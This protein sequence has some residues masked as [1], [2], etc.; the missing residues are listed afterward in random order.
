MSAVQIGQRRGDFELRFVAVRPGV[1][2]RLRGVSATRYA[3]IRP[4]GL[5]QGVDFEAAGQCAV[6]FGLLQGLHHVG[7]RAAQLDDRA[8]HLVDARGN[9]ALLGLS[10][11]V[12]AAHGDFF[13]AHAVDEDVLAGVQ[14]K[15]Q[16]ELLLLAEQHHFG[17]VA[18]A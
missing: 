4:A 7:I 14:H 3:V 11:G 5:R 9:D 2:R 12:E 8:N 16:L 6:G 15:R 18:A 13:A 17:Q 10:A 1:L